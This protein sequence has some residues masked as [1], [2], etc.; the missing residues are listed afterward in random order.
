ME[1]RVMPQFELVPSGA[2]VVTQE[3]S[4]VVVFEHAR[5]LVE[6]FDKL[7]DGF[8]GEAVGDGDE[9][10]IGLVHVGLPSW[11]RQPRRD[12]RGTFV[13]WRCVP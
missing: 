1:R 2:V 9:W 13:A 12:G 11:R 3:L 6:S 5:H 8:V 7:C 4:G 10:R